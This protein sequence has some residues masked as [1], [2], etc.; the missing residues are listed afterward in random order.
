MGHLADVAVVVALPIE[1]QEVL[2]QPPVGQL[3][4]QLLQRG[5]LGCRLCVWKAAEDAV[6]V[7]EVGPSAGATTSDPGLDGVALQV[8]SEIFRAFGARPEVFAQAMVP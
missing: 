5:P 2:G 4:G 7:G 8:G 3:A 6:F 1:P